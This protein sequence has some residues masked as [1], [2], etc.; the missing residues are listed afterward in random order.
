VTFLVGDQDL[1]N[2]KT[3]SQ[4]FGTGGSGI[5]VAAG[6][7]A[8]ATGTATSAWIKADATG[9][10]ELKVA[11]YDS[12][13][14]LIGVTSA[15]LGSGSGIDGWNELTGLSVAISSGQ[16]YRLM[17]LAE[18]NAVMYF[19]AADTFNNWLAETT[20]AVWPTAPASIASGVASLDEKRFAI[21]L[22]GTTSATV[23]RNMSLLGAG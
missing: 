14:A 22:D 13:N 21:Y 6:Y 3:T 4:A 18:F 11:I 10:S 15:Q 7:V 12:T 5:Y 9:L 20:T 1:G 23:R 19:D 2:A 8:A 17:I 16:T